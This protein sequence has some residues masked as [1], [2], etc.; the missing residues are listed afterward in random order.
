[1]FILTRVDSPPGA[2]ASDPDAPSQWYP[3]R[4]SSPPPSGRYPTSTRGVAVQ[5]SA[6]NGRPGPPVRLPLTWGRTSATLTA[7]NQPGESAGRR[8]HPAPGARCGSS[9]GLTAYGPAL[10]AENCG[11]SGPPGRSTKGAGLAAGVC[12]FADAAPNAPSQT[13]AVHTARIDIDMVS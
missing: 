2:D 3:K 5:S 1:A 8:S 12:P 10:P 13:A 6:A 11:R 4:R 7:P 9:R